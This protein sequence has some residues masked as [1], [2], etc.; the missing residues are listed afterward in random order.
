MTDFDERLNR[1]VG[2]AVRTYWK[3]RLRQQR[4]QGAATGT[5]DQ[6]LRSAVTGGAQLDGFIR[7]VADLLH[8]GGLLEADVFTLGRT[9][10]L[11]GYF[12]ATKA[13]DLVAVA[14]GKLVACV[15]VKSH[16]GPS[17]SNN[18]NNRIEEALGNATDLWKAYQHGAFRPSSRPFLGYIML[19]EAAPASNRPVKVDEPHFPTFPEF[20]GTSY[21]E[22]YRLFCTKLVRERLYDAAALL[23]AGQK[24]GLA[25]RYAEPSEELSFRT[26]AAALMGKAFEISKLR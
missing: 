11:P 9:T 19:L 4:M 16:A 23:T 6:G 8:E 7:L 18:F 1:R 3:T 12:R 14:S 25:G 5:K 24:D 2:D 10:V 13:W 22:R 20:P 15:E 21:T 26:F 17:F